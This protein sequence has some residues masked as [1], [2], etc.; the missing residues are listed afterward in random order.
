MQAYDASYT[1]AKLLYWTAVEVNAAISCGCIMTLKPLIQ[2]VFPRLL[3][4]S[5]GI[6][7]PSLQ[8]I[9]PA[10]GSICSNPISRQFFIANPANPRRESWHCST[11]HHTKDRS[12]SGQPHAHE[13][14]VVPRTPDDHDRREQSRYY[15]GI[16]K[17]DT[18][19]YDLDHDL[20]LEAQRTRSTSIIGTAAGASSSGADAENDIAP[21]PHATLRAPPRA[22]LRLLMHVTREVVVE[23]WPR[24][25]TP[26]EG[27]ELGERNAYKRGSKRRSTDERWAKLASVL[28][29]ASG[30]ELGGSFP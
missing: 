20:D 14:E 30:C 2:R 26:K 25:P 13:H 3:S 12:G 27:L 16:I 23:K 24:S 17:S 7:E 18:V 1:S 21:D 28:A 29:W 8:W 15:H 6:R 19:D 5:K 9:T 11:S 22:H 4:P 10:N